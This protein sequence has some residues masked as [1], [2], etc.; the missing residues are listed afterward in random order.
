MNYC[1]IEDRSPVMTLSH[2][3]IPPESPEQGPAEFRP[4]AQIESSP[5]I[6]KKTSLDLRHVSSLTMGIE[7]ILGTS[8][9]T[10][11]ASVKPKILY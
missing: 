5:V 6:W 4:P 2:H 8:V 7:I 10:A 9:V 11:F 1:S 3:Y